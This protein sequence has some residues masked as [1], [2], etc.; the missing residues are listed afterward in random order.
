MIE[1]NLIAKKTKQQKLGRS[2]EQ[3]YQ[4]IVYIVKG[5]DKIEITCSDVMVI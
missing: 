2:K 1:Q 5:Q 3:L 4:C